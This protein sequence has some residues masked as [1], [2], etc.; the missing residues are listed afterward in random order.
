VGGNE[1]GLTELFRRRFGMPVFAWLR[2]E[3]HKR[4]CGLLLST[5]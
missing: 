1:R 2:E 3:R 4:A 5:D